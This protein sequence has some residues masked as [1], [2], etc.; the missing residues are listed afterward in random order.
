MTEINLRP[1]DE[2]SRRL[3]SSV[4]DLVALLP[5]DWVLIGGLMVQLHALEA[6][7]VDVR[8]TIDVDVLGQARHKERSRRSMLRSKQTGSGR[9]CRISTD[10]HSAI[11][12]VSSSPTFWRPMASGRR[13]H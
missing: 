13:P 2:D 3:W 6:G 9:S 4:A 8:A 12:A 1:A 7:I 10:T 11:C 5:A